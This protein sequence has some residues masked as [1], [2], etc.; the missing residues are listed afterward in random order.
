[1][2]IPLGFQK[3]HSEYGRHCLELMFQTEQKGESE[4]S[5][6]SLLPDCQPNGTHCLIVSPADFPVVTDGTLNFQ[7]R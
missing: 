7:A 4:I 1:M 6:C 5:H 3:M 2:G